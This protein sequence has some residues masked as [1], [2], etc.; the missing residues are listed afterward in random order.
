MGL[1]RMHDV[2]PCIRGANLTMFCVN[3]SRTATQ[4]GRDI[5]AC[6]RTFC[7]DRCRHRRTTTTKTSATTTTTTTNAATTT[8]AVMLRRL[9]LP[10][11]LVTETGCCSL[12]HL[13]SVIT[14]P[15]SIIIIRSGRQRQHR[16]FHRPL[17]ITPSLQAVNSGENICERILRRTLIANI[18]SS[19]AKYSL[20]NTWL[21]LT[22]FTLR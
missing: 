3:F 13:R 9:R 22:D 18:K 5:H 17:I 6:C 20:M 16:N 15:K 7:F 8:A 4:R 12:R 11:R 19:T 21:Y 1:S 14:S 2:A 10:R